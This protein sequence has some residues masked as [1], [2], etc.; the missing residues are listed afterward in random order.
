MQKSHFR[1]LPQVLAARFNSRGCRILARV[2]RKFYIFGCQILGR[3][4]KQEEHK[5]GGPVSICGQCMRDFGRKRNAGTNFSLSIPSFQCHCN[6]TRAPRL[7]TSSCC[8][9]PK[10][11]RVKNT[12]GRNNFLLVYNII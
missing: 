10:D 4:K 8:S 9:Y 7:S 11:K 12:F 6:F 3:C 1:P 5:I 2:R